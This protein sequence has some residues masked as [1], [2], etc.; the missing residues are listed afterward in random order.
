MINNP[1]AIVVNA[2][3]RG[4]TGSGTEPHMI[5]IIQCLIL[6]LVS[7]VNLKVLAV[8]VPQFDDQLTRLRIRCLMLVKIVLEIVRETVSSRSWC[9]GCCHTIIFTYT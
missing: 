2:L 5:I 4:T 9:F 6:L 3:T 7:G 1:H 8:D